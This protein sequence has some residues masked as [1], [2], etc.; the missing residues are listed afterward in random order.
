MKQQIAK[1][2]TKIGVMIFLCL[3]CFVGVICPVQ[4]ATTESGLQLLKKETMILPVH[5]SDQIAAQVSV[6]TTQNMITVQ[7]L[8]PEKERLSYLWGQTCQK[9]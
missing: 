4:A 8:L 1:M 9:R 3:F 5:M 6:D 2:K 7:G